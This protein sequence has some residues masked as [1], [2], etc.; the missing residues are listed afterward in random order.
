MEFK[1]NI[2]DG[3]GQHEISLDMSL[4]KSNRGFVSE[5]NH[6]YPTPVGAPT[7]ADQLFAQ[8]GLFRQPA[9]RTGLRLSLIHI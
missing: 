2:D 5:L 1:A 6:R 9:G 4:Y 3:T 7:A 8:C